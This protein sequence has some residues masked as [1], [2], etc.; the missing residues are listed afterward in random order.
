MAFRSRRLACVGRDDRIRPKAEV[1]RCVADA[2]VTSEV[3]VTGAA[4][5]DGW[6]KALRR[7]RDAGVVEGWLER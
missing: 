1:L 5:T 3:T 2:A 4:C 7:C 6:S